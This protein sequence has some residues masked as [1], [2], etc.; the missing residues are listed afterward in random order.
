MR[1][2]QLTDVYSKGLYMG[3][4]VIPAMNGKQN[5]YRI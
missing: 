5:S 2:R 4:V 1:I 3:E